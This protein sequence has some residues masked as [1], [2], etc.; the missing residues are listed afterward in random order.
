MSTGAVISFYETTLPEGEQKHLVTINKHW[1]GYPDDQG[2]GMKLAMLLTSGKLVNGISVGDRLHTV[3]NGAGCLAAAFIK[4]IKDKVGDVYI[5]PEDAMVGQEYTYIVRV[6][7]D[8]SH[9]VDVH[10][11]YDV[12]PSAENMTFSGSFEQFLQWCKEYGHE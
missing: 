9:R 12:K 4:K 2:V 6:Y 3:W 7:A 10:E 1:D 5:V 8:L 11:G